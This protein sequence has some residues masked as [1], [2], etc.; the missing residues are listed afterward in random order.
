MQ[1][2]GIDHTHI[3]TDD[4]SRRCNKSILVVGV[5]SPHGND[6][7]GWLVARDLMQRSLN[8]CQA[9]IAATPLELLD[10]IED[11]EVLHVVD[12]LHG[13]STAGTIYRWTWPCA[14][15]QF[16]GWSG[17]HDFNLPGVL[18]LAEQLGLLPRQV[19]LW[20]IG[21]GNNQTDGSQPTE[22]AKWIESA[23]NQIQ[24]ELGRVRS[25]CSHLINCSQNF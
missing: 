18:A 5:G 3:Q 12:A 1:L 22:L 8:C 2:P 9:R 15:I 6:Q 4:A 20:G 7:L 10:W 21:V 14:E 25:S 11:C 17:T 24:C 23:A 16:D 13:R 19:F